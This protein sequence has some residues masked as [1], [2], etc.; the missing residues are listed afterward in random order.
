MGEQWVPVLPPVPDSEAFLKAVLTHARELTEASQALKR[1]PR[2]AFVLATIALEESI[3]AL[4]IFLHLVGVPDDHW[5]EK[6]YGAIR[7]DHR[8]RQKMAG[9]LIDIFRVVQA[10][11][12]IGRKRPLPHYQA[13]ACA[14]NAVR[15]LVSDPIAARARNV[16]N[17]ADWEHKKQQ[18]LYTDWYEGVGMVSDPVTPQDAAAIR[19]L[20]RSLIAMLSTLSQRSHVRR[21]TRHQRELRE[22]FR[23]A[24]EKWLESPDTSGDAP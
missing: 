18:A 3:K 21:L 15:R 1:Y 6:V 13:M 22:M 9:M 4:V 17:W 11:V 7:R 16:N 24:R 2:P 19:Q 12:P 10:Q 14:Q 5:G 23:A 8:L 20:A